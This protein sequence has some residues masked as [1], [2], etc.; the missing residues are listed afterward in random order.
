MC[1]AEADH[2][3]EDR[4]RDVR[5]FYL[6]SLASLLASALVM[7]WMSLTSARRHSYIS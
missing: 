3:L 7:A 2:I 5:M 1:G 4:M 6:L